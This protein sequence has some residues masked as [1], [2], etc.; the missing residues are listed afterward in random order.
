[1]GFMGILWDYFR[2]LIIGKILL[3]GFR[4]SDFKQDFS[5]CVQ[6]FSLL[7]TPRPEV[8]LAV[9]DLLFSSEK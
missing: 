9:P 6:D 5:I 7:R 8:D 3:L 1:M 4:I 2:I